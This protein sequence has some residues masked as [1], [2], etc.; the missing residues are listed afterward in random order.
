MP[1]TK[2]QRREISRRHLNNP[3]NRRKHNEH[4][5][6][7]F[8]VRRSQ[9]YERYMLQNVKTNAKRTGRLVTI[10]EADIIIPDV[11]PVLGIPIRRDCTRDDRD[12]APSVD[13]IDNN[14]GYTPD[15]IIIVSM[16]ANQ[17]KG[18]ATVEELEKVLFFYKGLSSK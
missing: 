5:Q 8:A 1:M 18:T 13:R 6:R 9:N 7:M 2:E 12:N 11:C 16:R 3:D 15:N 4:N 14:K 17:L 10:T